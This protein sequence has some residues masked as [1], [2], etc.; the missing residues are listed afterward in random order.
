MDRWFWLKPFIT[1]LEYSTSAPNLS[2]LQ[3]IATALDA[4]IEVRLVR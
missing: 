4:R 1:Q 3:K 2:F